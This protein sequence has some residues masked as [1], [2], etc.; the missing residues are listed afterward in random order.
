VAYAHS[1]GV[2]HR[3]IKPA[4][5]MIG[6]FGETLVVDWGLAK[7]VNAEKSD[8]TRPNEINNASASNNSTLMTPEPQSKSTEGTRAGHAVGTP[9]Y[10]SPEQAR[11]AHEYVGPASDIYSLGATLRS[12]VVGDSRAEGGASLRAPAAL[13]AVCETATADEPDARYATATELA[14]E[15]ERWLADEPVTLEE[16]AEEFGV[17]RERVRQIEV[18]AFEKVQEAVKAGVAKLQAPKSSSPAALPAR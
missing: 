2:I 14:A 3:D 4:N 8:L 10:M 17:S 18:R 11:G 16:L 12:L 7:T 5:I 9:A 6:S 1:K 15:V 13:L